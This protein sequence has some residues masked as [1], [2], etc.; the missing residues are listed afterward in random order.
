MK[1]F[2]KILP[3]SE[4]RKNLHQIPNEGGVYKQY[5]DKKGLEYLDSVCPTTKVITSDG[6]EVYLLYVGLAKNLF[7]R[8]RWHLG[9]TNTSHKSILGGWLST[10]RLSYMANHKE[11]LC[12][13]EQNKLNEFMDNHVY[14]QYLVTEDFIAVEEQLIKKND[15]P[16]NIKGNTHAFVS[17]N[18]SRRSTIHQ[19][20]IKE[21]SNNGLDKKFTNSKT[22][23]KA[24]QISP[25]RRMNDHELKQ[26]ARNAEKAGIKNKSNFLRWFRDIEKQSAS[27]AR[28][29][30]AWDLRNSDV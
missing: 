17:T 16:L 1:T 9:I 6:T 10:L 7:D 3:V 11:I 14:I 30:N 28:L 4:V 2:T 13:S 22:K 15:L 26:C 24:N 19:K 12:L 20:Y 29:Y 25:N 27:Q 21:H 8:F 18:I 5:V 23:L